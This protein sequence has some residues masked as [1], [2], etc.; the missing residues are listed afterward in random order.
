MRGEKKKKGSIA[1]GTV[2]FV[3]HSSPILPLFLIENIF[4]A[5][6]MR[7]GGEKEEKG[8]IDFGRLGLCVASI[9]LSLIRSGNMK[10]ERGR[11]GRKE[12]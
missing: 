11:G 8:S 3:Q 1:F 6:K 10:G 5:G 9:I 7:E 12:V 2:I 4:I